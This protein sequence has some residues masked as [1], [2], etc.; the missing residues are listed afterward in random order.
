MLGAYEHHALPEFTHENKNYFIY[1]E[2]VELDKIECNQV[3]MSVFALSK[4]IQTDPDKR[5]LCIAKE[6]DP[7]PET[8]PSNPVIFESVGVDGMQATADTDGKDGAAGGHM[9]RVAE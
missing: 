5:N 2:F 6:I 3:L 8:P 1:E 4:S 9:L 7:Y